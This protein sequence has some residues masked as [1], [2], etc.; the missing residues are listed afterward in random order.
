MIPMV[1]INYETESE[2]NRE[3]NIALLD[4]QALFGSGYITAKVQFKEIKDKIIPPDTDP[5]DET[6]CVTR[7]DGLSIAGYIDTEEGFGIVWGGRFSFK[8]QMTSIT[9]F[10]TVG[11]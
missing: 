11:Y 7:L 6:F 4:A 3:K 9:D 1:V 8:N 10:T 2:N 5:G